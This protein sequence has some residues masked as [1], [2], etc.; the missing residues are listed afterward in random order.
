MK[1]IWTFSL[2]LV[3]LHTTV[4]QVANDICS[5]AIMLTVDG[6][7]ETYSNRS[8]TNSAHPF[9]GLSCG[10]GNIGN[11]DVWFRSVV[12]SSGNISIETFRPTVGGL[13]D[14]DME[15]FKGVCGSLE[16][17]ACNN[18]KDRYNTFN[19]HALVELEGLEPSTTIFIRIIAP[20]RQEGDFDICVRD[21]GYTNPCQI[22]FIELGDQS[23]C[24]LVKNTYSQEFIVHYQ[25]DGSASG[26]YVNGTTVAL[27]SNPQT[28]TVMDLPANG[29]INSLDAWLYINN[30]FE[31]TECRINS[32]YE[33]IDFYSA[34]VNCFAGIVQE[35]TNDFCSE[36]LLLPVDGSCSRHS[37]LTVTNSAYPTEYLN[38][39]FGNSDGVDMW[40]K[41]IVPSS[42]NLTIVTSEPASEGIDRIDAEVYT[43][44]CNSLQLLS[45]NSA[46]DYTVAFSRHV[47][48]EL[49]N[50]NPGDTVYIRT[51]SESG[52][53]GAYDICLIDRGYTYPCRIDYIEVGAAGECDPITN[54]YDQEILVHYHSDSDARAEYLEINFDQVIRLT[55]NPQSVIL[56]DL[57]ANSN[58]LSL[59]ANLSANGTNHIC[60]FES[61]YT[62][63]KLF[64]TATNC[65][66]GLIEND[67]PENAI[68]LPI[69]SECLEIVQNNIGA[70]N[71]IL[72]ETSECILE[73][74]IGQDIW[75]KVIVPINGQLKIEAFNI[76][77]DGVYFELYELTNG[78][79]FRRIGS[80]CGYFGSPIS[81]NN[82]IPGDIL[83]IRVAIAGYIIG[84][85]MQS[86]FE[87][88]ITS[89]CP[90]TETISHDLDGGYMFEDRISISADNLIIN[91]SNVVY[92]AGQ[93]IDL[94]NGFEV[95]LGAHFEA[96]IE[97]CD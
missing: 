5:D 28:L 7:C 83:Y 39:G 29:E 34:P 48:I 46:Y 44:N 60:Y 31:V 10:F 38:C 89:D 81:L 55:G 92:S 36:A 20:F 95:E 76:G 72:E 37:N 93:F 78:G 74:E 69:N 53:R 54:T 56:H 77:D 63:Y 52:R 71:S 23:A 22:L 41:A 96:I 12:P 42:G 66:S 26:L 97:E 59:N 33:A 80:E 49:E 88:C 67:E 86:E 87:L 15:I 14:V 19:S 13:S 1:S 32:F 35:P 82:Q 6:S 58:G 90:D 57:P 18:I 94:E 62:T 24:D 79:V 64:E 73:C 84:I 2:Y 9:D 75:Y 70:T 11:G 4:A 30:R 16:T 8:A 85:E 45:C 47:R 25:S 43:G 51:M 3:F 27:T 21:M 68:L 40:F 17:L 65:F 91:Q 61:Q 50:L